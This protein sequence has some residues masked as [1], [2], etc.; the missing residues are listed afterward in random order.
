MSRG[1][2]AD[3][4]AYLYIAPAFGLAL[5]FSFFSM[6]VSFW[7]S[8][9]QWDPFAGGGRFVGLDNYRRVLAGVDSLFWVSLRN[10]TLYVVMVVVGM[11]VTALPLALLCRRVRALQGVFRTLY[12]LPSITPG[13]VVALIFYQIFGVFGQPLDKSGTALGAIALMGLWSGA[14]YNMLIFLAGLNEIPTDFY[15]AARLDGANSWQ[16]FWHVTLPMLRNTLVFVIV[17][18]II[19]AYQVFTSVYVMT[20]GGPERSTQVLAFDIF[21]NAFSVAGQMGYAS[22]AAWLLF[23]VIGVFVAIQMRLLRSRRIYDE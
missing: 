10:T 20:Q 14:G 1:K 22:A 6:G 12:F 4:T 15:E 16:E 23:L 11:L 19:G 9:H 17:M 21:M 8:L 18:T 5:L 2:R 3:W 13:V 7:T